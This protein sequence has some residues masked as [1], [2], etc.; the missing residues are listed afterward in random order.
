[1]PANLKDLSA[2]PLNAYGRA[3]V[4]LAELKAQSPELA[5]KLDELWRLFESCIP[6]VDKPKGK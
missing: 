3:A 5:K 6:D 4:L 2:A 1:M